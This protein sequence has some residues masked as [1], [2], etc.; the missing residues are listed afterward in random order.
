MLGASCQVLSLA[1]LTINTMLTADA[2][3]IKDKITSSR[4][5]VTKAIKALSSDS[6]APE[7]TIES[8]KGDD[9]LA[10]AQFGPQ[11]NRSSEQIQAHIETT[12]NHVQATAAEI[13]HRLT[14]RYVGRQVVD[15]AKAHPGMTAAVGFG[16]GLASFLLVRSRKRRRNGD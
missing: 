14:P 15:N 2:E 12:R 1:K 7:K 11:D 3:Q 8:L 4:D 10:K 6:L 13:R 5:L 9:T 16:T